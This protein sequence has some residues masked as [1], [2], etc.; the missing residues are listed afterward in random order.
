MYKNISK[1]RPIELGRYIG[2]VAEELK[3][4]NP[5]LSRNDLIELA[6]KKVRG[7]GAQEV[8]E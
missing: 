4:E 5:G 2:D 8:G 3:K 7:E 1:M 6:F